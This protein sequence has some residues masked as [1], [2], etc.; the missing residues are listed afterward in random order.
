MVGDAT[1]FQRAADIELGWEAVMPFLQAWEDG[2]EIHPYRA[3]SQGPVQADVLL[4]RDGR[5]WLPLD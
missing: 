1:L 4:A 2:G 5:Q 3:G